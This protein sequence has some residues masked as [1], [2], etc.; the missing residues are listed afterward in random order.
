M[1]SN[2]SQKE[3]AESI[4]IGWRTYQNYELG[5]REASAEAMKKLSERHKMDCH[6]LVT[7]EGGMVH[8]TPEDLARN[9]FEEV[10]EKADQLDVKIPPQKLSDLLVILIKAE[11][12]LHSPNPDEFE[13]L[14][15]LAGS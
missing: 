12:S 8:F 7:G 2:M 13:R 15:R 9:V 3:F 5:I 10:L 11:L 1:M 6:W 14:V 4:G